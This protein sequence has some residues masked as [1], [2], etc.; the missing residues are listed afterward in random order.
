[1]LTN[2]TNNKYDNPHQLLVA[3][4]VKEF[5]P[6]AQEG[7]CASYIPALAQKILIIWPFRLLDQIMTKLMEGYN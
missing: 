1:M 5:R 2:H 3:E 4:W 7:K 6:F